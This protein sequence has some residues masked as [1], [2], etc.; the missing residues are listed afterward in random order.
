MPFYS[1]V[2]IVGLIIAILSCLRYL[3]VERNWGICRGHSIYLLEISIF[4]IGAVFVQQIV[5]LGIY[6][7]IDSAEEIMLL[8][9]KIV[10]LQFEPT[11]GLTVLFMIISWLANIVLVALLLRI[12]FEI[13]K[14]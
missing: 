13:F 3:G 12:F 4:L 10:L 7:A 9:G 1:F 11:S 6:Y 14:I 5:T 8:F 2:A